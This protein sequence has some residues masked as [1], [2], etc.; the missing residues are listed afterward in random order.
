MNEQLRMC[1]GFIFQMFI[2]LFVKLFNTFYP[3]L[4]LIRCLTLSR[5]IFTRIDKM[6][7]QISIKIS[8]KDEKSME[9]YMVHPD[10]MIM[11]T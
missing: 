3:G 9:T 5:L 1:T 10:E 6:F 2:L 7:L 4:Q 11:S 8:D